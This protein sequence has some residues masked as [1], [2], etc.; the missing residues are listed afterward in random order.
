M[1]E[2]QADSDAG[3]GVLSGAA[4]AEPTD[5]F[6]VAQRLAQVGSYDIDLESV[7]GSYS[8]ECYR[9]WGLPY[10][11]TITED[12]FY[13]IVH[14]D[15]REKVRAS[16]VSLLTGPPKTH[17]VDYRIT[18]PDGTTR[19][20]LSRAQAER[21]GRGRMRLMGI[22]Q[23]ITEQ[24]RA[25][26]ELRASQE[27]W[28][29]IAAIVEW[30][31]DA[32]I[33]IDLAGNITSWNR[34]ASQ[35]FGH[36]EAEAQGRSIEM[37]TPD[38]LRAESTQL[39]A[40][41]VTRGESIEHHHTVRRRKDGTHVEISLTLSPIR[42]SD[43]KINGISAIARDMSERRRAEAA[44]LRTE[45][46]LREA[47]KM[48]AVGLLAGGIAHDFN[49]LLS[50]IVGYTELVL[51]SLAPEHPARSDLLEV[52]SASASAV[53][54]T[55]QLLAFS[56]R[57]MLQPRVINLNQIIGNLERM[58]RRLIGAHVSLALHL[59]A[60][61][62]RVSADPSQIEQVVM[63]LAI[64]GRD[65][66]PQGGTLTITTANVTLDDEHADELNL[67]S[68]DHVMLAVSDTGCG[69][70]QATK[71]RIFEP[72]FTTKEKGKGTGLG[73][74]TALGI[75]QQSKG[76]IEVDSAP[77]LG[78]TF[79]IYLPRTERPA[80]SAYSV[81]PARDGRK[82]WETVLLVEDD[83]QVR[84]LARTALRRCG[85]QVLESYHGEHALQV[86]HQYTG[87][88]H[89][90]LTDVVMPRMGGRELADRIAAIRPKTKV[91]FMSGYASDV[92][93]QGGKLDEGVAL[94]HKPITP[95]SLAAKVRE[96]L[97]AQ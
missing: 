16:V 94:L 25:V 78:T 12:R 28:Q 41:V 20:I 82:G 51:E 90:L 60:D 71:E 81:P 14:P 10:D 54:L 21:D 89:L 29:R 69:I 53:S 76:A 67:T 62:G 9:I 22:L 77:G 4:P 64:N 83:D 1:V 26:D 84:A 95:T 55:R 80:Q 45:Q 15:D 11:C 91:L 79:R 3:D 5:L 32:I 48:E 50:V 97:D 57:Q 59:S 27:R 93:S 86:C 65:A 49:N 33:G 43:G 88:I 7:Q 58:L 92:V 96:V 2:G 19:W 73:L 23:D 44:L 34:S 75:V 46:Q 61:L 38:S 47:Q 13:A 85:Y 35:L 36:G 63:N 39:F 17:E 6:E 87:T 68:G 31:S 40:R 74:S 70:D 42:G 72:F 56:R 18:K 37:L 52:R 24:K 66:M 30:S 8:R